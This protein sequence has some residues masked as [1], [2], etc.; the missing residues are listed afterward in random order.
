[1]VQVYSV[2]ASVPTAVNGGLSRPVAA[3]PASTTVASFG[4][5]IPKSDAKV[6]L[7]GTLGVT[8]GIVNPTLR[9][10]IFRGSSLVYSSQEQTVLP[11]GATQSISFTA[12]DV[13]P[14]PGYYGYTLTISVD[15]PLLVLNAT[16]LTGPVNFSGIAISSG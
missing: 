6:V 16:T 14:P 5:Y 2:G 8:A 1:M 15:N 13:N 12:V 11:V 3:T 4:L 7:T 10:Q 9:I